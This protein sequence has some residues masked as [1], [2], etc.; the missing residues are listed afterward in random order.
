MFVV[1]S[2]KNCLPVHLLFWIHLRSTHF[3]AWIL[4]VMCKYVLYYIILLLDLQVLML[5]IVELKRVICAFAK[6][7]DIV[8]LSMLSVI[9]CLV[10][11]D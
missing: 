7:V 9:F 8:P 4:S 3:A 11:L 6:D 10:F 2:F 1:H 5:F